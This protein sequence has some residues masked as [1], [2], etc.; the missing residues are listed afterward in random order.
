[1]ASED[2]WW[3]VA[4]VGW[5]VQVVEKAALGELSMMNIGQPANDR[6]SA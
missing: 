6:A 5:R 1:M 2:K 3:V 4:L